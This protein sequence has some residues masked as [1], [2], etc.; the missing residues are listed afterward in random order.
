MVWLLSI[1]RLLLVLAVLPWG[2]YSGAAALPSG[3][4]QAAVVAA[5]GPEPA[6]AAVSGDDRRDGLDFAS[7]PKRCRTAVLL[8]APCG[9]DLALPGSAPSPDLPGGEDALL[10]AD[11]VQL[12][13]VTPAGSLDPPRAC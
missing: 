8:G 9:P 12:A 1:A 7:K 6:G 3:D 13:G 5:A 10:P 2:A 11:G 4:H